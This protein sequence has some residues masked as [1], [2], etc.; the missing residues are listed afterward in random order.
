MVIGAF[1][2]KTHKP[3]DDE[4]LG[5]IGSKSKLWHDLVAFMND[6]Y[7]PRKDFTFYGKSYGW[8][9]RFRKGSKALLSLYPRHESFTVQIV[10][11][12][13]QAK[14]ASRQDL[15]PRAKAILRE[16]HEF[17]EGRWLFVPILSKRD[18]T[19]VKRL[20]TLKEPPKG[21]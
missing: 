11:S 2:D 13:S 3:T 20:V 7:V 18:L 15:G 1:V 10:L 16:T 8:A 5:L 9:V 6:N 19:D 17:P 4:I 12:K 21:V 14:I